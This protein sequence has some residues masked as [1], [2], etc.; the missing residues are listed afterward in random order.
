MTLSLLIVIKS[1]VSPG[2]HVTNLPFPFRKR[3]T[4]IR[5]GL[6]ERD[7]EKEERKTDILI[8]SATTGKS[9]AHH[10]LKPLVIWCRRLG[11]RM[12]LALDWA[13]WYSTSC[14]AWTTAVA[15]EVNREGLTLKRE[16]VKLLGQ[17][18]TTI[19]RLIWWRPEF[20]RSR[21]ASENPK[22]ASTISPHCQLGFP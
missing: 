3:R 18:P 10:V 7:R 9:C 11:D 22:G 21:D 1:A 4:W 15:L 8:P 17:T 13:H 19:T 6:I 16:A 14:R 12:Y 5:K 2:T 20:R